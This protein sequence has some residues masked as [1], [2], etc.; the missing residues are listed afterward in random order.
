MSEFPTFRLYDIQP[1]L[2]MS[3]R[4]DAAEEQDE[5]TQGKNQ[6]ADFG[7]KHPEVNP[8]IFNLIVGDQFAGA[9]FEMGGAGNEFPLAPGGDELGFLEK[10]FGRKKEGADEGDA[11]AEDADGF[12]VRQKK[13]LN[14]LPHARL[15]GWN[16]V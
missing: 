5:K 9:R 3:F 7:E 8:L 15:P 2:N 6:D 10:S 13:R 4:E 11:V 1:L 14:F 12:F 16:G